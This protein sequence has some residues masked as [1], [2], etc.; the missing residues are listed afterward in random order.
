MTAET[1]RTRAV[2]ETAARAVVDN[3]GKAWAD[4]NPDAFADAYTADGTMILSGDRFIQGREVIRAMAKQQ[5]ATAHKGT[6]LLQNVI[7]VRPVGEA[8]AVVITDGGVLAPGETAP[9]PDREIR[10]TWVLEKQDGNWLIAA[11]QNTR[12]ADGRLPGA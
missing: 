2:D 10:A 6:T 3:V 8:G 5:F 7:D 9:H 1:T 4:N 12:N 11:Y